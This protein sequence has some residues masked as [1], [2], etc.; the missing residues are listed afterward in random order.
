M[1]LIRFDHKRIS[2]NT[3]MEDS[4]LCKPTENFEIGYIKL[5]WYYPKN[6]DCLKYR[7]IGHFYE[8]C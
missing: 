5:Q 6:I 1:P 2:I 7:Y 3:S 4:N 8:P